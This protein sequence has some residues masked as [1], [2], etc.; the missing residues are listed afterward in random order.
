MARKHYKEDE[1][2]QSLKKK[3]DVRIIGDTI[4]VLNGK[5]KNHPAAN[6]LGNKSWGKIDFLV[7]YC[8]YSQYFCYAF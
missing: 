2:L 5:S 8:G 7:N 3:H 6:D 4:W 1:V